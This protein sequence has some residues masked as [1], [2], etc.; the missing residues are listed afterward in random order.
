MADCLAPLKS[1]IEQ[2]TYTIEAAAKEMQDPDETILRGFGKQLGNSKK[3]IMAVS[4][5]L[6]TDQSASVAVETTRLASEAYDAIKARRE[7]I[8]TA[9]RELGAASDIS[10]ASGPTRAQWL[11]SARPMWG[12][13]TRSGNESSANSARVAASPH[14]GHCSMAPHGVPAKAQDKGGRRGIISPHAGHDERS[15]E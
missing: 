5:G 2:A 11:P 10:E 7:L 12:T 1:V 3:E 14:A 6:M 13:Q 8:R 15:G 4:K 9:L